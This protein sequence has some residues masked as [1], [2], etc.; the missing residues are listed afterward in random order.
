MTYKGTKNGDEV[1]GDW[2]SPTRTEW[3]LSLV[4]A[5]TTRRALLAKGSSIDESAWFKNSLEADKT[6]VVQSLRDI[7]GY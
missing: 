7:W 4:P 3:V 2:T 6:G 5:A 1:I